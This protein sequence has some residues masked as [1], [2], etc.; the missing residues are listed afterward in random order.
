MNAILEQINSMGKAFVEFAWPMLVQ[1]SVLIVILLLVD[2]AVRKKVRAVFRYCIWMLVLAKLVLPS[3]LSSPLSLGYLFGDSLE[4]VTVSR[5]TTTAETGQMSLPMEMAGEGEARSVEAISMA[6]IVTPTTGSIEPAVEA[7]G[8]PVVSMRQV[9]WQGV[10]FLVWLAVVGAMA[11]LLLQRALFVRGLVAQARNANSLINDAF[12]YCC[13]QMGMKREVGL[14]VSANATG[15]AVCGLFRP[16]ILVPQN[17]G[18]SLGS[19]GLRTVLLHELAHIKRRDLGVNLVQTVLQIIYFY[20]PLLWLA[21]AII[22]RVR[23]QAVDETVQVAMGKRAQQYPET[24]V[25]VAKLAFRRPA[26]SLRLIGVVESESALKG[27]IK[28]MLNR[29]IPKSAKL[30]ILGL[31]AIFIIGA[32]LL[33]MAA[34]TPGAPGLVIKGMVKD[35]QTGKPIAGARVFDDGY[36]HDPDW[37]KVESG[38]YEPNLPHWGDV[39]DANGNYAFLTHAEHH[40]FKIE[41]TGYKTKRATLYSGHFTF[42]KKDE[43]VFDFELVPHN[44]GFIATLSNGVTVELVG[45]CEHPSEGKQW[46]RPDGSLLN[47][48]PYKTTGSLLPEHA[49]Y[50]YCEFVIRLQDTDGIS[51]KWDVPGGRQGSFT[52][53]PI[54]ANG[55]RISDLQVYTVNQPEDQ[56]TALVRIG[57]STARWQAI[58]THPVEIPEEAYSIDE[59]GAVAFGRSYEKDS[60]TAIPITHNINRGRE[61]KALRVV[62]VT[63][64]GRE[65]R[66]SVSGRG[67]NILSSNTHEFNLPLRDIKEFQFQTRPYEWVEFKNVS[68]RPGVKGDVEVEVRGRPSE[69]PMTVGRSDASKRKEEI[70]AKL[71]NLEQ[72]RNRVQRDL[73]S[74]ERALQDVRASSGF[75]D[76][77]ERGYRHPITERLMRLEQE[78]DNCHLEIAQLNAKIKNL[79]KRKAAEELINAGD[80]L[81]ALE[82][83]LEALDRMVQEAK[84]QKKD[85]DRARVQYKQRAGIRDERQMML[86]SLKAQ[87]EKLRIMYDEAERVVELQKQR[88]HVDK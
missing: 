34:F 70:L 58:A 19:S 23:E 4:N 86:D 13:A 71:V 33:P 76:L 5:M 80:N 55:Q 72:Q 50:K 27:R 65:V 30:G 25:N 15:P 64:S 37:E 10:V 39:T 60:K 24:L 38:F 62:A 78:R 9:T 36:A 87:I 42:N 56:K 85:L 18:P 61:K 26:L 82:G 43:E 73:G 49:N 48:T 59:N 35:A 53:N 69:D 31:I 66:G 6:P 21:N 20:N 17:L 22:R 63:Y 52:G 81:V 83:K 28:R 7:A 75:T 41:A 29:P 77:E 67:G 14:K 2:L 57:L 32:V 16:V 47:E 79:G 84:A 74:A 8:A 88:A 1:S 46:W 3:S 45:V 40:G 12:R 44:S 11:L 51:V 54:G 68:L